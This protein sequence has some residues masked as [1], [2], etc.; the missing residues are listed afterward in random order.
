MMTSIRQYTFFAGF[1]G[2]QYTIEAKSRVLAFVLSS[3]VYP[4]LSMLPLPHHQGEK[5]EERED[6]ITCRSIYTPVEERKER[7][8]EERKIFFFSRSSFNGSSGAEKRKEE[9]E[10]GPPPARRTMGREEKEE[11]KR[12]AIRPEG[13]GEIQEH[14]DG[15]R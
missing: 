1:G 5:E 12:K 7:E 4:P 3:S 13:G 6:P 14:T 11:E 2:E 9:E 15:D 8:E 10:E